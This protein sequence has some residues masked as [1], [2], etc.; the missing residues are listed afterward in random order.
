MKV[1]GLNL[2]EQEEG[3]MRNTRAEDGSF[4]I[5]IVAY[6]KACW[7]IERKKTVCIQQEGAS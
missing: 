5:A 4:D 6:S 7:H 3:V 1:L 2:W